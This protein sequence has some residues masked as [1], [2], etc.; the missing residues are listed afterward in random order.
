MFESGTRLRARV[1]D[2]DGG[3]QAFLGWYDATLDVK[4]VFT[5]ASDGSTRCMPA[6][7]QPAFFFDAACTERAATF[8]GDTTPPAYVSV[9]DEA[10][11]CDRR[12]TLHA[13]H[14]GDARA[15]ARIY[16]GGGGKCG[17]SPL[18]AG[19]QAFALSP[20]VS[21]STFAEA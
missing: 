9:A 20:E 10:K 16:A 12:F 2:G 18:L 17:P 21:P 15:T 4:C 11:R 6:S 14:V 1:V 3:A 5:A 8:T 13:F 19:E 7:S